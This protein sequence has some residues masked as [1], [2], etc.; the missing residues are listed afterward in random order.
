MRSIREPQ[1]LVKGGGTKKRHGGDRYGAVPR[2]HAQER[3]EHPPAS[4]LAHIE[5]QRGRCTKPETDE[6]P[7]GFGGLGRETVNTSMKITM[8]W[9]RYGQGRGVVVGVEVRMFGIGIIH[10]RLLFTSRY[11]GRCQDAASIADLARGFLVGTL[12]Y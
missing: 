11:V 3:R 7:E 10:T 8:E 2:Q 9:A 6:V 12:G 5:M 4:P 1:R